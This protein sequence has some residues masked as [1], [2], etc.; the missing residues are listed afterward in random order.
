MIDLSYLTEEE[1]EKIM[2]V[3][4][5]DSVLKKTE[6][7]RIK[8]LQENV[9]DKDKLKF[10]TGEWFYETKSQRHKDRIHGSDIIRASM[11]QRRSITLL[12]LTEM[13]TEK[14]SFVNSGIR[15]VFVPPEL[16]GLIDEPS[17]QP[18][19]EREKSSLLPGD[20]KDG[21]TVPSPARVC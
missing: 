21:V 18:K 6:E 7:E 5:R 3:L 20:Q 1:Q 8:K 9:Q 17:G 12:E 11:K 10:M 13:W 16:S 19:E 15:D 2:A 4:N 14:P